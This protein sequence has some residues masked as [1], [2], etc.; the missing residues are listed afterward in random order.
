MSTVRFISQPKDFKYFAPDNLEE[1]SRLLTTYEKS[2][3]I[4]AGGTDVVP[5][6]KHGKW[7]PE[8][9]V[10]IKN[11]NKLN[12]ILAEDCEFKIGALTT[13]DNISRS[14]VIQENFLALRMAAE[15]MASENVRNIASIGGNICRSSPSG[16]M[17]PPLM[18]LEAKLKIFGPKGEK[19]VPIETFFKGPGENILGTGE[20][21]TDIL[22]SWQPD[23]QAFCKLKRVSTDLAKVN[24]CVAFDYKE[25]K[26][27]KM[28]IAVGG[29][30]PTVVR[31]KATEKLLE[32]I[33]LSDNIIQEAANLIQS[34]ISP[35]SDVRS[36]EDYRR[37]MSGVLLK[38]AI[39]ISF[40]GV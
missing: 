34:E 17:I 19:F 29:V 3:Q 26:F 7:L 18:A 24:I 12:Y 33:D 11:I 10:N 40:K 32:G 22:I 36:T 13:I 27:T 4:F 37:A 6:M 2:A 25:N 5:M 16:D 9:V 38:R 28:R 35:I 30:A 15:N 21:V 39:N 1:A 23:K 31:A 8:V 14:S 20:I